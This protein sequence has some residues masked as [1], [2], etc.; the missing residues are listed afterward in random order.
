MFLSIAAKSAVI[1]D[2]NQTLLNC[3]DYSRDEVVGRSMYR[4]FHPICADRVRDAFQA[5]MANKEVS[6][7][8][9][10]LQCKNGTNIDVSM[11]ASAVCSAAG[12]TLHSR[13]TLHDITERK[14][15]EEQLLS[16]KAAAESANIA[17]SQFLANMSHEIRTPMNGLLGMTQL[18]E[19]TDLTPEQQEYISSLKLSGKILLNLI[20]NILD[21]S[22]IEAGKII[23]ESADF[24]L[25]SLIDEVVMAQKSV[26]FK[27]KL[28]LDIEI[29]E[30][31]PR[32]ITGDQLRVKQVVLNLLGNAIK[33]TKAGE[34]T[35]AVQILETHHHA[36]IVQ[37][38]IKDTGIGISPHALKNIFEPFVQEDGSTTRQF[39][40]SGLGLT[41]SRRLVNLMGGN[42]SVDSTQGVGSCFTLTLPFTIPMAIDQVV[43]LN[44]E[45]RA[46]WDGPALRIL[47]VED[48]PVNMK[49]TSILLGKHGHEVVTAQNGKECLTELE[50]GIFDLVLMDIQMPVMNG[51]EALRE[52][53]SKERVTQFHQRVI[54]LTAHALQGEKKRFFNEGFDGYLSK[55]LEQAELIKEMRR[56]LNLNT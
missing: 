14:Q 29:S 7:V 22:K 54:A 50:T 18:L 39:G 47:L 25:H 11:N 46:D 19:Y 6:N 5:F 37:I 34:I 31:F 13:T 45:V 1:I 20:N 42:L 55:P 21:L 12:N 28:T 36:V 49:F 2:C 53:R 51:E 33:F 27:K 24:N 15:T 48:N 8:E 52:I 35:I 10:T 30:N 56:V 41:I 26:L 16:A 43:Q 4:L 32:M 23:I 40:G 44:Q 38:S 3:T 17:K 9:L